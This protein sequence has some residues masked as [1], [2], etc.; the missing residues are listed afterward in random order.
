[1]KNKLQI[2]IA[3]VAVFA[4]CASG[5]ATAATKKTPS[6]A[7]NPSVSP[8][9]KSTAS[10]TREKTV[11]AIP[12]HG[13][14]AAV[15]QKAKTFTIAGK[16]KSRVFKITNRTMLTKAGATATMKDVVVNEEVRGS[17]WKVT[18][19]S[20][21]A[22]TVKLGPLTEKEKAAEDARKKKRAEKKAAAAASTT[23]AASPVSSPAPTP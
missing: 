7:P 17:Y 11:R 20:L 1:M 5:A 16:E 19:G 6:P 2:V 10:S 13:K 14:I 21:E 22:K 3:C 12:F 18:D 9:P 4:F 15:D 23:P 8:A